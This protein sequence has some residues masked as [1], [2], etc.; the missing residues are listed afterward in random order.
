MALDVLARGRP[1]LGP[2]RAG[3][4]PEGVDGQRHLIVARG[5][6]GLSALEAFQLG[7]FIVVRLDRIGNGQQ[8]AG[9]VGWGRAAEAVKG[10]GGRVNG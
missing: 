5:G 3:H 1:S 10:R 2:C 6:K 8:H 4:E 7:E 9:A